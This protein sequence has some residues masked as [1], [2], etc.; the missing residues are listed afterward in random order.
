[1]KTRIGPA[2]YDVRH[3]RFVRNSG[4]PL[5]TFERRSSHRTVF[6]GVVLLGLLALLIP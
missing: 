5:D 6:V 4:L 3:W 1:M 2:D